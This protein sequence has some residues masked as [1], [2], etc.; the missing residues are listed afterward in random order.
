M[1]VVQARP[2]DPLNTPL[3]D[4]LG[5]EQLAHLCDCI[6][7]GEH[8][9]VAGAPLA[10]DRVQEDVDVSVEEAV[11]HLCGDWGLGFGPRM[12]STGVLVWDHES[13]GGSILDRGENASQT[14]LRASSVASSAGRSANLSL[15]II[16]RQTI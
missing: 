8:A 10:N 14:F 3:L 1:P 11:A 6:N 13:R 5:A 2:P 12:W 4:E 16:R 9:V 7:D 15:T